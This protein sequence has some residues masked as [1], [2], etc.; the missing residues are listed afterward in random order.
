MT[1][2]SVE[3]DE[4]PDATDEHP[5]PVASAPPAGSILGT[6]AGRIAAVREAETKT[7][8]VGPQS[9]PRLLCRYRAL[10]D[11]EIKRLLKLAHREAALLEKV[12]KKPSDIDV[13]NRQAGLML[14][15]AC[16]ALV[17][18][19]D[20]GDEVDLHEF[21]ARPEHGLPDPP[22][23]PLRYTMESLRMLMPDRVD[24]LVEKVRA[25]GRENPSSVDV[26][27]EMHRWGERENHAPLRARGA[28]L[29]VWSSDVS[30]QALTDALGG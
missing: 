26:V 18:V 16:E 9:R 12:G 3:D 28:E 20:D 19:D 22:T 7:W 30:R 23:E 27:A 5:E 1:R 11:D 2:I 17:W 15:N 21:L 10:E 13:Q 14:V 25:D 6:L 29:Q 4:A 24:R 8:P